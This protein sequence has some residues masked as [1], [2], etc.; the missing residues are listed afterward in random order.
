MVTRVGREFLALHK[1]GHEFPVEIN[2]SPLQTAEGLLVTSAIRDITERK[3]A[4]ER[5]RQYEKAMEGLEEM[6]AVVDRDYRYVIANRAFLK[7]RGMESEQLIGR[8]VAEVLNKG[9]FETVVKEKLDEAF[10]GKIVRYEMKYNYPELGERDLS[11]SYF[12]IEE[13]SRIDRVA[14][15]LQDITE[16]KRAEED[17]RASEERLRLAQE[18]AKIGTFERNLQTGEI[19]WNVRN[20]SHVWA[21][22]RG[23]APRS[24][25][26]FLDLV[27]GEDRPYVARLL[28]Q[29]MRT[30]DAEG[31]WRVIWPDGTVHWIAGRW[32]V[33]KRRTRISFEGPRRGF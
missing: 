14:A 6:I 18:V 10:Q 25:E 32:R 16:R 21:Y 17:L 31:E 28:E 15:V 2:L 5:L 8:H 12:P 1:D 20:G 30:G 9:V 11:I 26:A 19:R 33:F 13:R 24:S 23:G 27:H 4:E 22:R 29:S 7:Y 3:R